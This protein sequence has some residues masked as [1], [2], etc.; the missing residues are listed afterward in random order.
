M[1][2][3]HINTYIYTLTHIPVHTHIYQANDIYFFHILHF[4]HILF[5]SPS[6]SLPSLEVSLSRAKIHYSEFFINMK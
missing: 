4:N 2:S 3:I 5:E 6:I 1:E